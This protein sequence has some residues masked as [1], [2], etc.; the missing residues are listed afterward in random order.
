MA[1]R[2]CGRNRKQDGIEP[3]Q[4]SD[5]ER[6]HRGEHRPRPADQVNEG[7]VDWLLACPVKDFFV[8]IAS[9]SSDTL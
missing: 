4:Q 2:A 7:L 9:E 3:R 1:N 5:L 8:P 6:I